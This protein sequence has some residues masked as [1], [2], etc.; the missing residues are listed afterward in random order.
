M[1][2]KAKEKNL[3]NKKKL[4]PGR[5]RST[6]HAPNCWIGLVDM[7][8][9]CTDTARWPGK[10]KKK[11]WK[12]KKIWVRA[13]FD[14]PTTHQIGGVQL[15]DVHKSTARY[16]CIIKIKKKKLAQAGFELGTSNALIDNRSI[17]RSILIQSIWNQR[18]CKRKKFEKIKKFGSGPVSIHRP[19][20]K[21]VEYS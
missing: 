20:T 14:P 3:K 21:L 16:C 13:G 10:Q 2:R 17:S 4:D 9:Q 19:R 1:T 7:S 12:N 8:T 18:G 15:A 6:D 11:I 5:F